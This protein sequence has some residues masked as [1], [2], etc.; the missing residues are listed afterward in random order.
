VRVF[1]KSKMDNHVGSSGQSYDVVVVGGESA[2]SLT[3]YRL[4]KAGVCTLVLEGLRVSA[5]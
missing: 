4:A 3:A 1:V 2:G 5:G